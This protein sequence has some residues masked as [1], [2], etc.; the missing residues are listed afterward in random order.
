MDNT[1]NTG[2][3]RGRIALLAGAAAFAAAG[4]VFAIQSP[5]ESPK[6]QEPVTLHSPTPALHESSPE[7][8]TPTEADGAVFLYE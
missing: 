4:I 6:F 1:T 7:P 3:N 2:P 5:R 8:Y